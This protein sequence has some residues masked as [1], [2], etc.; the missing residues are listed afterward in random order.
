MPAEYQYEPINTDKRDIRLL[1][2]HPAS[3]T[4][5][6]LVQCSF[7]PISLFT[8]DQ[9]PAYKTISYTWGDP[10]PN[11]HILIE[12]LPLAV[13]T[14]AEKA[15]RYFRL[16]DTERLIWIDAACINQRDLEGEKGPH[17]RYMSLVYSKGE[18]NLVYLGEDEDGLAEVAFRLV[19]EVR[20]RRVS[21]LDDGVVGRGSQEAK[22]LTSLFSRAWF[23]RAWW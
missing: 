4:T 8:R 7:H 3:S 23:R 6:D 22:A 14:N 17:I 11:A 12:N 18:G 5:T 9:I 13:P 16:P 1:V 21:V 2:V 19:R 20:D 15:I 10:T